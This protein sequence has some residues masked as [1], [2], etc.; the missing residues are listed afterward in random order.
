MRRAEILVSRASLKRPLLAEI[1]KATSQVST[2]KIFLIF[3]F[4]FGY[5]REVP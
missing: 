1:V 3:P 2:S 5:V 4:V